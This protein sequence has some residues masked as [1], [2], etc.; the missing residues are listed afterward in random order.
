MEK[1]IL[2][3]NGISTGTIPWVKDSELLE[4]NSN[5]IYDRIGVPQGGAIS[6]LIANIY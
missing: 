1:D 5:P 2:V 3:K 4:L 6:C